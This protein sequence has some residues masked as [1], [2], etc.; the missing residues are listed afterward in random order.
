MFES[1]VKPNNSQKSK[2]V[3]A[4]PMFG[5]PDD[6]SFDED[7]GVQITEIQQSMRKNTEKYKQIL[8]KYKSIQDM[9][10]QLTSRYV[11]NLEIILDVSKILNMYMETFDTI[12]E[13]ISKN[14]DMLSPLSVE[15]LSYIENATSNSVKSLSNTLLTEINKLE[16]LLEKN[17]GFSKESEHL[18]ALKLSLATPL[19]SYVQ[20]KTG[21]K[22]LKPLPKKQHLKK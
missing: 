15:D 7:P 21:G 13:E 6:I 2:L 8:E 20:N 17:K 19:D 10:K 22:T 3:I 16:G 4:S 5:R 1:F 18:R 12:R 9:N 14:S 11:K